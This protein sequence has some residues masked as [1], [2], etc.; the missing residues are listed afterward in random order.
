ML[1]ESKRKEE[2]NETTK[3][4]GFRWGGFFLKCIYLT[5][6][7]FTVSRFRYAAHALRSRYWIEIRQAKAGIARTCNLGRPRITIFLDHFYFRMKV[8][9]M[10]KLSDACKGLWR[11]LLQSPT[12][13]V[14]VL[15]RNP[16]PQRFSRSQT[17]VKAISHLKTDP[18]CATRGST[19]FVFATRLFASASDMHSFASK[20]ETSG[21][22]G[23]TDAL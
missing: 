9:I 17:S 4:L 12:F 22:Q 2:F 13:S 20:R 18:T 14:N 15:L 21:T 23:V 6:S 3:S 5:S 8:K 10:C 1:I 7:W 19:L 16:R 11:L